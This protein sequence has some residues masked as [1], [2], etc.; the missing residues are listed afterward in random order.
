MTV[1]RQAPLSMGILQARIRECVAMPSSRGTFQPK[2]RT[3]ISCVSCIGR[4]VLYHC[5]T[6]AFHN[7]MSA[8]KGVYRETYSLCMSWRKEEAARVY[9]IGGALWYRVC[10]TRTVVMLQEGQTLAKHSAGILYKAAVPSLSG[11]R[12]QFHGRSEDGG[13]EAQGWRCGGGDTG[14]FRDDSSALHLLY[15]LFLI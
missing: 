13:C 5:Y 14:W 8:M 3:R 1:A 15:T 4:W 6:Q 7:M 9:T 12:D 2:D 10:V 11:T